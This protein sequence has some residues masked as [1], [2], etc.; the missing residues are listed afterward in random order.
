M[1]GA[2][3][4][5]GT[6]VRSLPTP[7]APTIVAACAFLVGIWGS[8]V[9]RADGFAPTTTDPDA[10][11]RTHQPSVPPAKFR[12]TWDLDG[13]YL[14]LGPSGAGGYLD[15]HWDSTFG[16]DFSLVRVREHEL[17]G[18]IGADLGASRWTTRD[19]GL[20]WLDGLVGTRVLGHMVGASVGPI[21]A[22]SQ[23]DH[24]R[25]G[26]S[27][28]VWAFIGVTPYV[29]VGAVDGSGAFVELGVHIALPIWR[30]H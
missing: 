14:W 15:H 18:A 13:L 19:A 26:A 20:V 12:P 2:S 11:A 16:G 27:V 24:P 21:L 25:A 9:A 8:A 10:P 7:G 29:R 1:R 17:L 3:V 30:R 4:A 23:L 6:T 22:L 28:G 5:P